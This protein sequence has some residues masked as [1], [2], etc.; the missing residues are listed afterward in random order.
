MI[1]HS[2][3]QISTQLGVEWH[4]NVEVEK[5]IIENGAATGIRLMD[6]S[7]VRARKLV[8]SAGL[9]PRQV[10]FDLIG[11]EHLDGLLARRIELACAG[12]VAEI[13]PHDQ[14]R[15]FFLEPLKRAVVH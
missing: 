2:A 15:T 13:G 5:V 12:V 4:T 8:V 11:R 10:C 14:R 9:H 7:E 3:H 1:A 6:G